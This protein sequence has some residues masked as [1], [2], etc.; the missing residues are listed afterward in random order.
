MTLEE[1]TALA[2][3]ALEKHLSHAYWS[4][5]AEATRDAALSMAVDDSLAFVG[6]RVEEIT[7]AAPM[8]HIVLCAVAEQAVFLARHYEENEGGRIVASESAGGVSQS[9]AI[10]KKMADGG[11]WSLRAM[12]LLETVRKRCA[13]SLR[14]FRG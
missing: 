8:L 13:G 2:K 1:F 3:A 10:T 9:F 5:L 6:W 4:G 11:L 12:G 14:I 7:A